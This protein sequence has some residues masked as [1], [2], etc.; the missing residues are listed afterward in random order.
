MFAYLSS[1]RQHNKTNGSENI[2]CVFVFYSTVSSSLNTMSSGHNLCPSGTHTPRLAS[3]KAILS[4]PLALVIII[5]ASWDHIVIVNLQWWFSVHRWRNCQPASK[6]G[7]PR[8]LLNSINN[9]E[10]YCNSPS[11]LDPVTLSRLGPWVPSVK[12][13]H[14][15]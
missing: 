2:Y 1:A 5:N 15:V 13:Y 6:P 14:L 9:D 8:Y 7:N 3:S 10:Q 11:H 4:R 12:H